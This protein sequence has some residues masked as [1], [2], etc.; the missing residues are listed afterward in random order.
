MRDEGGEETEKKDPVKN[1]HQRVGEESK[2]RERRE[3]QGFER[4]ETVKKSLDPR[5]T[6]KVRIKPYLGHYVHKV[7]TMYGKSHSGNVLRST[8]SRDYSVQALV[9]FFFLFFSYCQTA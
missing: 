4:E 6:T 3:S 8:F 9:F 2:H 5:S 1:G 7:G